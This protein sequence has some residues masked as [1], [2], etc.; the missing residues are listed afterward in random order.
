[1]KNI[2]EDTPT[3]VLSTLD[4]QSQD[5]VVEVERHLQRA[6]F[7]NSQIVQA[8][9]PETED[10]ESRGFPEVLQGRWRTD[11]RHL[12]GSAACTLSHMQFYNRREDQLPVIILED[13]VT[14]H[15]NFF[16]FLERVNF[17]EMIQWD[18][19][20]LSY[21]N[22]ELSSRA[23]PDRVV[24]P[25]LVKCAPNRVAGA[26]SYIVNRPFLERFLPSVEEVDWQ[27]AHQTAEIASYVIEHEPKLTS[28]NFQLD[29][30]RMSLDRRSWHQ[31]NPAA[32]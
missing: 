11:L 12:W 5:R 26:Y 24:S 32:E 4:E 1:M 21:F 15:P 28:P 8:K 25:H 10:F 16:H 9:T 2:D 31:N 23:N 22:W 13:D 20:H 30:V 7:R 19:C 27:F 3:Y 18:L 14:I 17:P 29:S 6:G